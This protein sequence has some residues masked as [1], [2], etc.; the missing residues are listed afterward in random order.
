MWAPKQKEGVLREDAWRIFKSSSKLL[1]SFSLNL[2]TASN[3]KYHVEA[4]QEIKSLKVVIKFHA[5][6]IE[7]IETEISGRNLP[8]EDLK[9]RF[10]DT[11]QYSR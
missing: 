10:V 9:L 8:R 5:E 2:L 4:F 11:D 3:L 6:I 1:S 7:G